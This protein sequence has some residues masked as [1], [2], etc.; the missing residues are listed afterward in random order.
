MCHYPPNQT[1]HRMHGSQH[2]NQVIPHITWH[3]PRGVGDSGA[4]PAPLSSAASSGASTPLDN[5]SVIASM[6]GQGGACPATVGGP[7]SSVDPAP[8][9]VGGAKGDSLDEPRQRRI[10]PE[11]TSFSGEDGRHTDPRGN[12]SIDSHMDRSHIARIGRPQRKT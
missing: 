8:H 3:S 7:S 2:K 6:L 5:G 12:Q 4:G 10:Q 11:P 9:A 1:L